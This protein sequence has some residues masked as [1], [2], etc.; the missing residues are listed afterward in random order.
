M[1][2][3]RKSY[4]PWVIVAIGALVFIGIVMEEE[5][6]Y[7][8]VAVESSPEALTPAGYTLAMGEGFRRAMNRVDDFG[9]SIVLAVDSSGSMEEPPASGGQEKYLQAAEALSTVVDYLGE[10]AA[11]RPD[12]RLRVGVI[13]FS[14]TVTDILPL[15][16]LDSQGIAALRQACAPENFLPGGKTAIG[17]ALERGT[18]LLAQSGTIFTS[19]LVISDGEN[20]IGPEPDTVM[21]AIYA[22][23]NDQ[24]L[25]DDPVRTDTQLISII[26]FDIDSPQFALLHELGARVSSASDRRELETSLR[27]ILEADITK[28]E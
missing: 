27:D 11:A 4:L 16:S 18:A 10:L 20:T 7:G 1:K 26:G 25:P 19:L 15:T 12:M 6:E 22:N 23:R 3:T 28:L 2:Q 13:T 8:S 17:L 9:I 14:D 5:P 21:E 24:S